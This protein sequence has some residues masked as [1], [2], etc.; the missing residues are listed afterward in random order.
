MLAMALALG[1][2]PLGADT[3]AVMEALR[4]V[5]LET[6]KAVAIRDLRLDL[7][8]AQLHVKEG[9]LIPTSPAGAARAPEIVFVGTGRFLLVAPDEIEAGQLELFSG[10]E[11]LSEA[12]TAAVLA[13]GNDAAVATLLDRPLAT[14]VDPATLS[15]ARELFE[16]WRQS[17][18]RRRLGIEQM[19]QLDALGDPSAESFFAARLETAEAG[20][21][22][23]LVEPRA[24]EQVTLGQFVPIEATQKERRKLARTLLR[25]QR[26]GRL[27]NLTLDDIGAWDTWVST[28]LRDPQGAPLP[29]SP[30]FD[31]EHTRLD[32]R[33]EGRS[34]DLEATARLTLRAIHG[35]SRFA[36][37]E[38][39]ND[40]QVS[41]VRDSEGRPLFFQQEGTR[42]LVELPEV[43][44]AGEEVVVEIEY[45]GNLIH[46]LP[47][48]SSFLRSTTGWYPRVDSD[49]LSTF[50]ATFHWPRGFDLVAAGKM[51]GGDEKGTPQPWSRYVVDWPILAYTF[52][53]GSFKKVT[54]RAGM[55]DHVEVTFYFDH[56]SWELVKEN[57]QRIVSTVADCLTY[58]EQ[59]FGPYPLDTMRV[60]T[61]QRGFSQSLAGFI[62][63]SALGVSDNKGYIRLR[64]VKDSRT[65]IA[66]EVSHQWWGHRVG[67]RSYRDQ[68]ISEAMANYSAVLYERHRIPGGVATDRGLNDG[69]QTALEE[70]LEDGRSTESVG[71]V[72][73]GS[74]L[75]SS[76]SYS[77]YHAIVYKKGALV[78]EML[79]RL[80]GEENFLKI[81]RALVETV[82]GRQISTE[83]FID[84]LERLT[85]QDL[86][87]FADQFIYRTGL[88]EVY[89]DWRTQSLEE[90]GWE[91]E[92]VARQ[93]AS[94]RYDHRLVRRQDGSFDV[95]RTARR[96]MDVAQ[97]RLVVPVEIDVFDPGVEDAEGK[98]ARRKRRKAGQ[99]PAANKR[100][101]ATTWV[102]GEE[103]PFRWVLP[104]EPRQIQLDRQAEVF[105]RFYNERRFP[106]RTLHMR[107]IDRLASDDATAALD[108]LAQ[109]SAATL[110]SESPSLRPYSKAEHARQSRR[111]NIVIALLR[112]RCLFSLNRDREASRALEGAREQMHSDD[113]RWSRIELGILRARVALRANAPQVAYGL[114][115]KALRKGKIKNTEGQLLYA[116]AAKLIGRQEEFAEAKE[117]ALA[118]GADLSALDEIKKRE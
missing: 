42:T 26:R 97:S 47:G 4:S 80:F 46:R 2:L 17:P 77:A 90:G 28:S 58:F 107:A 85:D 100:L 55:D 31:V 67:W 59:T 38:M 44:P 27:L 92:G 106:K 89:Y 62:T 57:R 114:L 45:A 64:G 78:L 25:Q 117:K 41:Q 51:T 9:I 76:R 49:D 72:V 84:F 8:M 10:S 101:S 99:P 24:G 61:V 23:Y 96:E 69:W 109:A 68:W 108:L 35:L 105:G 94:Y 65:L 79:S 111:F 29:G 19:Q 34:L 83:Q 75:F 21:L 88:T 32:V 95:A 3:E 60:V 12:T 110:A 93:A 66:H 104:L 118:R 74:R 5:T 103:M 54:T 112:A 15:Q 73:L 7:G 81:Q 6:G 113:S 14:S 37:F 33:L 36:R 16:E 13:I 63:L 86:Q 18:E 91:I 50:E 40:L 43:V 48:K 52:E 102:G 39:I 71:P 1:V 30:G 53:A 115:R 116:A 70:E 11:N 20:T 22:L 82:D 98:S 56:G 87:P